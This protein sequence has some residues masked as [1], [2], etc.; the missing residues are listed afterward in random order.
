MN[1]ERSGTQ[2]IIDEQG[3]A[4]PLNV[5]EACAGLKSLMTF[6][7][8]F[9]RPIF[10][11]VHLAPL[12]SAPAFGGSIDA[13][14]DAALSDAR[15]LRDGGCDGM[16][17]ENYGDRPFFKERVEAAT[18]AAMTGLEWPSPGGLVQM[19]LADGHQAI[20]SIAFARTKYNPDAKRVD[21][22]D[23]Q[24]FAAE[25]VNPPPGVKSL[26]WIKGGM[27]GAKCN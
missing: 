6:V 21:L 1:V 24:Y 18:V 9:G 23:I 10:G 3:T 12:P 19:K 15:A 14:I 26:D 11:M 4:R 20:Q 17:F 25:C 5:A 22:V 7:S 8:R 2:I 27:Q 13:V 16:V